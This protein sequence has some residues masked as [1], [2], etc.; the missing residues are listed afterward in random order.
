VQFPKYD[1]C[2]DRL[3]KVLSIRDGIY[4]MSKEIGAEAVLENCRALIDQVIA[5]LSAEKPFVS[6]SSAAELLV[7]LE[8]ALLLSK[9]VS[10]PCPVKR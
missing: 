6:A 3:S 7:H 9:E 5:G 8:S 1:C 10:R 2:F 4:I